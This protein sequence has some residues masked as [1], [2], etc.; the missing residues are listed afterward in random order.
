V[1]S[2]LRQQAGRHPTYPF[3]PCQ[4]VTALCARARLLI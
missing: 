1:I 2:K 3:V 4:D